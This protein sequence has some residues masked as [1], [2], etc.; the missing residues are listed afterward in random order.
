MRGGENQ[1]GVKLT[2]LLESEAALKKGVEGV[3]EFIIVDVGD[4][5]NGLKS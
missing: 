4:E 5:K 3:N 1:L 2:S